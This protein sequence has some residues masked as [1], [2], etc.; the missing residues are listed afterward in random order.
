MYEED[1]LQLAKGGD[2]LSL[3]I[4][5]IA[6]AALQSRRY[7]LSQRMPVGGSQSELIV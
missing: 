1:S 5:L 3:G 6:P 4:L 2:T 7:I